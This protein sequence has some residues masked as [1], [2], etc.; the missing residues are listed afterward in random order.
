MSIVDVA[1]LANVSAATVSRVLNKKASVSPE[2]AL[3]VKRAL[4]E[5]NYKPRRG[6]S[7]QKVI[8]TRNGGASVCKKGAFALVVPHVCGG[9]YPSLHKGFVNGGEVL[10]RRVITCES[11]ND[12]GKQAD[13]FFRLMSD[14]VAGIALVPTTSGSPSAHQIQQLQSAGIPVVLLH[15]DIDEV[16]APFIKLP[17]EQI[18]YFAARAL[19][20]RGHKSIACCVQ[21]RTSIVPFWLA[22][23]RRGLA[24][25]DLELA[26]EHLHVGPDAAWPMSAEH[27]A[28][29]NEALGRML[30]EPAET[31]PTAIWSSFDGDGE[32]IY[33]LLNDMGI[34]IPDEVSLLSFGGAWRSGPVAS[35]LAAITVNE[36]E[37]GELATRLLDEMTQGIRDMNDDE[38]CVMVPDLYEGESL[39]QK[40][41]AHSGTSR[42]SKL[43]GA[44]S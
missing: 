2:S 29:L 31:R 7:K 1:K 12:L 20:E 24:E 33:L 11:D 26:D 4:S 37:T 23:M 40:K 42:D 36:I 41:T 19:V 13:I 22:G 32:L 16:Q 44:E 27:I 17:H 35:R 43:Q 34:R 21:N 25:S 3:A 5:L 15:R 10:N 38:V 14:D 18:S 8:Q 28:A 9:F 30:S 6:R 39:I